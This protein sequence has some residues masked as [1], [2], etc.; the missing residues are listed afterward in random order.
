MQV[1]TKRI[2]AFKYDELTND[3]K[4]AV[5]IK[6]AEYYEDLTPILSDDFIREINEKL[7]Y[8][9]EPKLQW[10]LSWSQGD[11]VS[12]SATVNV[13]EFLKTKNLKKTIFD[14][15]CNYLQ[16]KSTGNTGHYCYA[17]KSD[18]KWELNSYKEYPRLENLIIKFIDD[19]KQEYKDLCNEL[20]KMGYNAISYAYSEENTKNWIAFNNVL[21]EKDGTFIFMNNENIKKN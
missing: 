4:E 11:G 10:S 3:V 7:P 18:I 9:E 13:N 6:I 1:L 19:L 21:F 20:E 14:A 2:E 12:F 5:N 16:I 15:L 17:S 8:F